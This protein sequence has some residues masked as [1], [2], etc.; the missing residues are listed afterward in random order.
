MSEPAAKAAAIATTEQR[1]LENE[2]ILRQVLVLL[3]GQGVFVRTVA[4]DWLKSYETV[5][6]EAAP[7]PGLRM[8]ADQTLYEAAFSSVLC[9]ELAHELG[10]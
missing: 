2:A 8:K 5:L 3:I 6:T 4:K 1:S 9:V 7:A 10:P